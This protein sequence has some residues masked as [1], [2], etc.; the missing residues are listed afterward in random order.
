MLLEG[1]LKIVSALC[2]ESSRKKLLIGTE[3]GNIYQLR[4]QG[5]CLE[6]EIIFQ[7]CFTHENFWKRLFTNDS[8][9]LL[10]RTV[11][12][13][14]KLNPGAVEALLERPGRKLVYI[15]FNFGHR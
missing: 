8:Q 1:R 2:L 15:S 14:Y 4:L 9:D 11:P 5:F 12:D 6:E 7:V 3:G 13:N 10:M